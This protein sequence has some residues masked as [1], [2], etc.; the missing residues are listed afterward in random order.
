MTMAKELTEKKTGRQALME[1]LKGRYPELDTE[2]DEAVSGQISSDYDEM[3]KRA[4]E[5]KAFND[6]LSNNPEAAPIIT[7]LATGKNDDGSDF[8][9]ADWLIDNEPELVEDMIEGNAKTKA[10]YEKSRADRKKAADDEAEFQA[11]AEEKLQAMDA[12][13]DAAAAEAGYR[14]EDTKELMEWIFGDDGLLTKARNFDLTKDDF[15]R[16]IRIKDY[17]KDVQKADEDGYVRGKNEKIDMTAH[18]Q[19]KRSKLPVIPNGGGT[20]TT[21]DEDPTL[22]R[23]KAMGG[24]Y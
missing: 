23:L 1:R 9:L 3:D 22:A 2:D 6:M 8:N 20:P 13:L 17:D 15:L 12:E 10:H 21:E 16:L 5:R 19:N 4:E 24:V 11:Q 7:G 14:V 18:R